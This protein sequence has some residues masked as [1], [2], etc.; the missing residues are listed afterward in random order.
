[1]SPSGVSLL[2]LCF[3]P[4]THPSLGCSRGQRPG[5]PV[6]GAQ[7]GLWDIHDPVRVLCDLWNVPG[8]IQTTP[9]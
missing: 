6:G 8:G 7:G 3:E 9:R 2:S 5:V 1:M 4:D